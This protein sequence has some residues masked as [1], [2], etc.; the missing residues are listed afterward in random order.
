MGDL[1]K[2]LKVKNANVND[3]LKVGTNNQVESS[4]TQLSDLALNSDLVDLSNTVAS[5]SSRVDDLDDNME[6]VTNRL[7]DING[8]NE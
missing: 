4:G 2:G 5:L 1:V 6:E 8:E 7:S 3:V